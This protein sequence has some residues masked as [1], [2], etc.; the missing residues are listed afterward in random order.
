M[1]LWQVVWLCALCAATAAAITY[2]CTAP[3]PPDPPAERHGAVDLIEN[4]ERR[5]P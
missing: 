1:Q 3:P 5:T 2:I 4:P